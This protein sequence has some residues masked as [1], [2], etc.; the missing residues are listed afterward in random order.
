VV[1]IC[2]LVHSLVGV[3]VGGDDPDPLAVRVPPLRSAGDRECLTSRRQLEEAVAGPKVGCQRLS[4]G[5]T[6]ALPKEEE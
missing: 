6:G 2:W 1:T 4:M 5:G 3:L